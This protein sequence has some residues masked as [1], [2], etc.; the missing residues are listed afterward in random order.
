MVNGKI[1]KSAN[2]ID[3]FNFVTNF[4]SA[5]VKVYTLLWIQIDE[6]KKG[7]FKNWLNLS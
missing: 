4:S 1:V 5:F 6:W 7:M 3:F 2:K